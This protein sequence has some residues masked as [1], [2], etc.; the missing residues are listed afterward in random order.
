MSKNSDVGRRMLQQEGLLDENDRSRRREAVQDL[1]KA[2]REAADRLKR[3]CFTLWG[4]SLLLPLAFLTSF[5]SE[6]SFW[7]SGVTR[8]NTWIYL[9]SPLV[10]TLG[11]IFLV[12]AIISTV[13]WFLRSRTASLAAI[14]AHL[15]TLE[16]LLSANT[17]RSGGPPSV[18]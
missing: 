9:A 18:D 17:S 14:A 11:A 1:V 12:A 8:L 16:R 5:Y 15:E 13:A 2:E 3:R 6:K 4:F 10:G 7:M